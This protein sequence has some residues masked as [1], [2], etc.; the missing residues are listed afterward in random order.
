VLAG[1]GATV[2]VASRD[3]AKGELAAQ[4][5]GGDASFVRL[6]LASLASVREA[7]GELHERLARID[8]LVNN[9]GVMMTPEG[10]T[11]DGFELQYGT[12]Y[13]G[14]FALT[15]QLLDLMIK[16]PGSRVVTVSSLMYLFG[17]T[18]YPPARYG[19]S[20][21]YANSKLANLVFA[22]E[23]QRR[24]AAAGAE[25]ISLAAHPGYARTGLTRYLP[26]LVR[27]GSE[28]SAP[29]IAQSAAMG[30]L[31]ILRAATDPGAHGGEF[32]GPRG[33]TRGYPVL[34]PVL[35][36]GGGRGGGRG[37]PEAARRL[38]AESEGR[39]GITFEL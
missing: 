28:L 8:L 34:S 20:A 18:P 30:A 13:L 21:A 2:V 3:S 31:P 10:T 9:A 27:T 15:G 17:R 12:N 37:D 1:R 38:W 23:L 36:V 25:T 33:L 16:V 5:I 35:R 11:E 14:H 22:L 24:L 29:V 7:A 6:D 32:Y 39:T 19:P 26:P 4:Q